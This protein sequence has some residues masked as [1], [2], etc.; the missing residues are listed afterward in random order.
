MILS[1]YTYCYLAKKRLIFEQDMNATSALW[2]DLTNLSLFIVFLG[3]LLAVLIQFKL[4]ERDY[5]IKIRK[6]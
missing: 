2:I 6:P 3:I 5:K 4:L 1:A